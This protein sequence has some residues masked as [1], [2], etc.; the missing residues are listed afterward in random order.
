M[1]TSHCPPLDLQ[2][3]FKTSSLKVHLLGCHIN[4]VHQTY[5]MMGLSPKYTSAICVP[6][7]S[8]DP[9]FVSMQ[10]VRVQHR[11]HKVNV[12]TEE[13]NRWY[14]AV[15]IYCAVVEEECRKTLFQEL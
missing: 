13:S 15:V 8:E 10:K 3:H 12:E 6:Q 4:K 2:K 5:G 11:M 14:H 1:L 7:Q 9:I